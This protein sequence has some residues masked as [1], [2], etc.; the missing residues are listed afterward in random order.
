MKLASIASIVLIGGVFGGLLG[1][2]GKCTSG[3]CPLTANPWRGSIIGLLL[4]GLVA[5]SIFGNPSAARSLSG[6][7]KAKSDAVVHISGEDDF[8][9]L[10]LN[11]DKPALVDFYADWCGPCRALS[12]HVVGLAESNDDIIVAKIDVDDKANNGLA[13]KYNVRAIPRLIVVKDGEVAASHTGYIKQ[14][15][16]TEW[17]DENSGE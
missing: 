3:A 15:K 5:V 17:V 14:D 10:V 11:A 7:S 16:L 12:P 6:K 8:R 9:K 2:F 1:Y 4:G 13:R